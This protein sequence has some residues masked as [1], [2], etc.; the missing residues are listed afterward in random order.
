MITYSNGN[1]LEILDNTDKTLYVPHIV[2]DNNQLGSGIAKAFS[3]KWPDVKTRYHWWFERYPK[4]DMID[5][6]G[7]AKLGHCQFIRANDQITIV[8]MIAQSDPGGIRFKQK[9]LA[10]IRYQSLEE[11]MFRT[12]E[13]MQRERIKEII[14]VKFGSER[15]GGDWDIIEKMINDIWVDCGISVTI[16]VPKE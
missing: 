1:I 8:N 4:V 9:Y 16:V 6:T 13:Q 5:T 11:C 3:D 12:L 7:K 15:A 2:N 14:T 10:P